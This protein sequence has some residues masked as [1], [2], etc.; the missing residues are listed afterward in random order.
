M[1][2]LAVEVEALAFPRELQ[3]LEGLQRAPEALLA[4]N[5]E[6]VELILT[7]ALPDAEPDAPAR[8]HVDDRNILREL[9]RMLK[10]RE[11]D[12][13]SDLNTFGARGD[14]G[15]RRHHRGKIAV[16]GEV[17]LGEPDGIEAGGIGHLGLGE[18]F[19]IDFLKAPS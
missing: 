16:V 12:E 1:K 6:A 17:M 4:R 19:R 2:I 7:I 3:N 14:R 8:D 13:G 18:H 10:R 9:Q 11:Q 5:A 15:R